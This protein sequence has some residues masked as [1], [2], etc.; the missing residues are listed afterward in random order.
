MPK[1]RRGSFELGHCAGKNEI[2]HGLQNQQGGVCRI[3]LSMNCF[4][5]VKDNVV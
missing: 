4:H 2:N 5:T 3:C 1:D